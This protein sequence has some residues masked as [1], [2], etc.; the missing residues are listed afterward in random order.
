MNPAPLRRNIGIEVKE[1]HRMANKG[2][3]WQDLALPAVLVLTGT[4]LIAAN[5]LGLISLDRIQ[6]LWPAAFILT[7][8]V[9]LAPVENGSGKRI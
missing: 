8:L 6:D 3:R 2:L 5:W 9:Q 4:I 7:G 1:F